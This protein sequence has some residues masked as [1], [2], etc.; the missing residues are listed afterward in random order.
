LAEVVQVGCL[1]AVTA[2]MPTDPVEAVAVADTQRSARMDHLL[3]S[4]AAAVVQEVQR[5]VAGQEVSAGPVA[6]QAV[7]A[8]MLGLLKV[9]PVVELVALVGLAVREQVWMARMVVPTR[10]VQE[11]R[12]LPPKLVELPAVAAA[13]AVLPAVAAA[14]AVMETQTQTQTV[15]VLAAAVAM[16]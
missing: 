6:V 13:V 11:A 7:M 4:L 3:S 12:V 10:V 5:P 9:E 2:V 16:V 14:V 15:T 8:P 1:A